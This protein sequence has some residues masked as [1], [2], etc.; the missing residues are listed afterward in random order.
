MKKNANVFAMLSKERKAS[1]AK[2]AALIVAFKK[3]NN[4]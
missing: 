2:T 1:E 4:K 3:S